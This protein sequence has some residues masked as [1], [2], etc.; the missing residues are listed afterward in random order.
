MEY[1]AKAGARVI[2]ILAAASDSTITECVAAGRE[3]GAQIVADVME[4]E[5]PVSRARQV[6]DL[7]VGGINLHTPIDRQMRAADSFAQ[8]RELVKAVDVPVSVAG[9]IKRT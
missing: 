1:A 7:G 8:L 6:R 5:D 4:L 3:Y 2:Y 9:G